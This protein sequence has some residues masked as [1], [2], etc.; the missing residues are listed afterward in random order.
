MAANVC[1]PCNFGIDLHDQFHGNVDIVFCDDSK[2]KANSVILS[3]NSAT[4]SKFFSELK[5]SSIEIKDFTKEAVI[6]FLECLYSGDVKLEK[7]TFREI[8]KLSVVFKTNWLLERSIEFFSTENI[9]FEFED[10]CFVFD[11]ADYSQNAMKSTDLFEIV[12]KSFS[13]N[14]KNICVEHHFNK[15]IASITSETLDYI[16]LLSQENFSPVVTCIKQRLVDGE[17]D[18]TTRSLL[19]NSMIVEWFVDNME[20]YE[21]VYELLTL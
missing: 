1:V 13:R 10:L 17:I 19:A 12:N 11:G 6:M 9:L 20:C 15:N 8:Y 5:L 2:I 7:R 4:F 21:D 14:Q 16:L 3:L 18:A